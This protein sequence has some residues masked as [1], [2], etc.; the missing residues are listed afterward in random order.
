M[1]MKEGDMWAVKSHTGKNMGKYKSKHAA[2]IRL[3][4]IEWFKKHKGGN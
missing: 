4:A 2:H 3:A 1:I